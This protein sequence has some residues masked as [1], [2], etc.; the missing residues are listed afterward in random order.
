[1]RVSS[2]ELRKFLSAKR[3]HCYY[4]AE[5]H[6]S[7]ERRSKLHWF[8]VVQVGGEHVPVG[9]PFQFLSILLKSAWAMPPPHSLKPPRVRAPQ[10][11]LEVRLERLEEPPRVLH[12][13]PPR[14]P[15]PVDQPSRHPHV[16]VARAIPNQPLYDPIL[17][18]QTLLEGHRSPSLHQFERDAQA[19]RTR[20]PQQLVGLFPERRGGRPP[21]LTSTSSTISSTPTSYRNTSLCRHHVS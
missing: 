12:R 18:P 11:Q 1:M 6:P 19:R 17:V 14:R 15:R 7:R 20:P 3:P 21:R 16:K 4:P 9:P 2:S 10:L 13:A 8:V 5:G